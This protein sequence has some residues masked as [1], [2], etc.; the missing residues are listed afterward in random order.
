MLID[1]IGQTPYIPTTTTQPAAVEPGTPDY[2]Q[3]RYDDFVSRN[4][5]VDPP[6]Y[7]LEYG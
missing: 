1:G 4:P 2:Y 3:Q 5:G 6:D 7:Y